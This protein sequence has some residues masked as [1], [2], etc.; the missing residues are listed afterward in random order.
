LHDVSLYILE[1][2][3]NSIRA[4]AGVIAVAVEFDF[5]AGLLR[6]SVEDDGT[7]IQQPA[8]KLVDPFYTTCN[9]K[10]V[11]LGLSL[12]KGVAEST[13][14][15]LEISRSAE[16]GGAAVTVTMGLGHVDRPPLGD[17]A[18]TLSTMI[19]TN[20]EIDFRLRM[21]CADR[22]YSFRLSEFARKYG[23][24]SDKNI[25]LASGAFQILRRDLEIW[26]RIELVSVESRSHPPDGTVGRNKAVSSSGWDLLSKLEQGADA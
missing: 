18:S 21:R 26:K 22:D 5:E 12:L 1:L 16:L 23:L 15:E 20:P 24:G 13:G 7:G 10:K 2:I 25:A 17:L 14:G 11:G 6:V 9:W 8:E 4:K 19:M 3:E